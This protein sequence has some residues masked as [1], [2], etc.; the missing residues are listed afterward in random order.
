M[1]LSVG[2]LASG[3]DTQGIISKLM[4][5]ERRPITLLENREAAFK[6]KLSAYGEVKSALSA[7]Q[8]AVNDLK[9]PSSFDSSS[10][11]SSNEG[12]LTVTSSGSAALGNHSII[13]S[14]LAQ[15]HTVRSAAFTD[16]TDVVGTGT[17][18][19]QIGA[20][21]A[22]VDVTIDSDHETVAG[23]AAAINSA[24]AGVNASVIDDG[25]G[26]VYLTMASKESGAGNTISAT[27]TNGVTGQLDTLYDG[28]GMVMTR[29]AANS[30]L[31]VDGI[32]VVRSTNSI[33][34]LIS[35]VALNLHKADDTETVGVDVTR[36]TDT[37]K[38]KISAFV[39]AYNKLIDELS[40]KQAYAGEDGSSGALI[41]DS[42]VRSITRSLP[43][44]LGQQVAGT[45]NAADT[46]SSIGITIDRYGKMQMDDSAVT[47]A[48][49]SNISD[50]TTI[51]TADTET[52]KGIA[53]TLSDYLAGVMS[54]TDGMIASKEDGLQSSIDDLKDKQDVM[55]TRVSK[56]EEILQNQF[57]ALEKLISS[58]QQTSDYLTQ[59]LVGLSNLNKQIAG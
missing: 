15:A 43:N 42:T 14:S 56:R 57:N 44:I 5:L 27:I 4:D 33:G 35:G 48:L 19:I 20:T 23:I 32:N 12:I 22:A 6:V 11:V 24:D 52:S 31:N 53:T 2:G 28:G 51:F 40:S 41:G 59:Q 29:A 30:S 50:V 49:T 17:I 7:F 47:D 55:E 54:P 1:A 8:S 38:E 9:Y 26:H 46:L 16:S 37:I 21:G 18:S 10:S 36:D 3:L 34:D 39:D 25:L 58:Y 13:V 45:Q